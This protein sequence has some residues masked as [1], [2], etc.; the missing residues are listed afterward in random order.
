VRFARRAAGVG[1]SSPLMAEVAASVEPTP[2]VSSCRAGV[3]ESW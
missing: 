2:G 1:L 3:D